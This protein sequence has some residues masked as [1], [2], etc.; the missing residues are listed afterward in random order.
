MKP[1]L[2]TLGTISFACALIAQF[3]S[4]G[5]ALF[6]REAGA[7]SSLIALIF[8]AGIPFTLRFIWAPLIDR[9][10][11]RGQPRFRIWI[12]GSQLAVSLLLAALLTTN[13]ETDAIQI[14]VIAVLLFIALGT[15]LTSLGGMI[16][17]GLDKRDHSKGASV[18]AAASA[19]A[20][21]SL[22]A[23]V[24]YLLGSL[25]WQSVVATLLICSVVLL[26]IAYSFLSF[27]PALDPETKPSLLS[28]FSILRQKEVSRLFIVSSLV[29]AS[30]VVPFGAKSVLLIDAG[31]SVSESGLISLVFGNLLGFTGALLAKP[32]IDLFGGFRVLIGIG[33]LNVIAALAFAFLALNEI[34]PILIVAS[35]LWA[36]LVVYATF[37][38]NR[39]I[40]LGLCRPGRQATDLASFTSLEALVFLVIAGVSTSLLDSLGLSII[41]CFAGLISSAGL[42][43]GLQYV[44]LFENESRRPVDDCARSILNKK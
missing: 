11:V 8:I 33:S 29:S 14:I 36:N 7:S 13:P 18:Q 26:V 38:A 4:Q 24:L 43:L 35:I 3:A 17:E 30:I 19:L 12:L 6:L 1:L 5:I 9:F 20:G 39:T 31:F 34:G 2:V 40:L 22:G 23:G 44:Q 21:F 10:R 27:G 41:L 25:G 37:T 28:Q 42:F 32:L 16:A 15:A